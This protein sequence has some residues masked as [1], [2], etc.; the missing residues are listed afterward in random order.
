[1]ILAVAIPA[2][3]ELVIY[4]ADSLAEQNKF[5]GQ[6]ERDDPTLLQDTDFTRFFA[7]PDLAK[8]KHPPTI[9]E[10][11][12]SAELDAFVAA[13]D[14]KLTSFLD[15]HGK[16]RQM[17]ERDDFNKADGRTIGEITGYNEFD[18]FDRRTDEEKQKDREARE[19]AK[20]GKKKDKSG[21]TPDMTEDSF[22]HKSEGYRPDADDNGDMVPPSEEKKMSNIRIRSVEFEYEDDGSMK[23]GPDGIPMIKRAVVEKN[24]MTSDYWHLTLYRDGVIDNKLA[25]Y[26]EL[27]DKAGMGETNYDIGWDFFAHDDGGIVIRLGGAAI[28]ALEHSMRVLGITQVDDTTGAGR[29]CVMTP[30]LHEQEGV[31]PNNPFRI[32]FDP[33]VEVYFRV[34][35]PDLSVGEVNEIVELQGGRVAFK[36]NTV[37]DISWHAFIRRKDA[38]AFQ[39]LLG[40]Q[41][42][43]SDIVEVDR[44]GE[45]WIEAGA[46][47]IVVD[48]EEEKKEPPLPW[49]DGADEFVQEMNSFGDDEDG[50]KELLKWL[51]KNVRGEHFIY[52]IR[53]YGT[54]TH[55]LVH[56]QPR[57]YFE[58][59][60]E[61]WRGLLPVE[62]LL[63]DNFVKYGEL[64]GLYRVNSLDANTTDYLL[65]NKAKMKESLLLRMY[66]N[67]AG[68]E[69]FA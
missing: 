42:V 16:Q 31:D 7:E 43:K 55:I 25:S 14:I 24:F 33:L 41:G 52:S 65:G 37:E 38:E 4:G 34:D 12:S 36:S 23:L 66:L 50:Q 48:V 29:E 20:S 60:D 40:K 27:T 56:I 57:S 2:N 6:V 54:P 15:A 21:K 28:K 39:E 30:M 47:A 59:H 53:D 63:A 13:N 61:L 67:S 32:T 69:A 35:V 49:N 3:C 64:P 22:G 58:K 51:R 1:M 68:Q 62:H 26:V 17:L 10:F 46:G 45:R 18:P 5:L 8:F 9:L 19:A 44:E 11:P